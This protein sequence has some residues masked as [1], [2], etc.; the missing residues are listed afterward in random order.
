MAY[1]AASVNQAFLTP[2]T[3]GNGT[4]VIRYTGNAG[5]TPVII[6]YSQSLSTTPSADYIRGIAIAQI[7]TLN[8]TANFINGLIPSLPIALDVTTPIPPAT[9]TTGSYL[10]VSA[11]FTPGVTPTDIATIFGSATKTVA[12]TRLSLSTIQTTAG[13]NGWSVIKRSTANTGGTSAALTRVPTDSNAPAATATVLQY[14]ANP[15]ALGT[16][17]GTVW[18]GRVFAPAL[19]TVVGG[20]LEIPLLSVSTISPLVL[21]GVAQ[22]LAVNFGGVALPSGLSV[23]VIIGWN[24]S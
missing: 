17:V 4:L 18:S 1:N 8:T 11:P 5:E 10:A 23:Q 15:S 6:Q 7:N 20:S 3:S 2:Q 24:E 22:G 19:A 13:I 9:V 21:R 16:A 12:V 14:T